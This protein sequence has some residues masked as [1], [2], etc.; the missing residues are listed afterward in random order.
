[1]TEAELKQ[2]A[3]LVAEEMKAADGEESHKDGHGP[4][5]LTEIELKTLKELLRNRRRRIK[6]F[7]Y[8]VGALSLWVLKDLYDRIASIIG[9]MTIKI[10]GG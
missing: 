4:V 8:I 5:K 10:G 2:L 9:N 6:V 1:M 3:K 7:L